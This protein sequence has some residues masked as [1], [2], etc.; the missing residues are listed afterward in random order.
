MAGRSQNMQDDALHMVTG[1]VSWVVGDDGEDDVGGTAVA[2]RPLLPKLAL[3]ADE[4]ASHV[5]AER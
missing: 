5:V 3:I 4:P 1:D 2:K